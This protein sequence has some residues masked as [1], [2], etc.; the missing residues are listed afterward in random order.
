[1]LC[2]KV[3]KIWYIMIKKWAYN[4]SK[5]NR[6]KLLSEPSANRNLACTRR[7]LGKK[8][9]GGNFSRNYKEMIK[10]KEEN[11]LVKG[12]ARTFGERT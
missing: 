3:H 2:I 8:G 12:S 9:P 10:R 7:D 6:T 11:F 5:Q 4:I 1:M